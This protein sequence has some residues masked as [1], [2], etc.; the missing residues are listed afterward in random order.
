MFVAARPNDLLV[1]PIAT[2]A[3][4]HWNA[5]LPYIRALIVAA[6]APAAGI[7]FTTTPELSVK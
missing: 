2:A 6:A 3:V 7:V 1:V 4:T 5:A